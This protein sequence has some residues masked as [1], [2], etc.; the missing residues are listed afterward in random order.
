MFAHAFVP[1]HQTYQRCSISR[2]LCRFLQALTLVLMS[3]CAT[4]D[5]DP[6][7]RL[8][9]LNDSEWAKAHRLPDNGPDAQWSHQ[10]L[11]ARIATR[12]QPVTHAGRPALHALSERGDSLVRLPVRAEGPRLGQLRF[13]WF[14]SELNPAAELGDSARD[15]AVVRVILQFDGDRAPF[16][17][18]DRRLSEMVHLATGEPLPHATLMYVWDHHHPVGTVLRHPRTDRVRVLVVAS[19]EAGLGR[20]VDIER[21]IAADY[22]LAFG[23]SPVRLIGLAIMTDANNTGQRAEAWYGPITWSAHSMH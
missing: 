23:K 20:W 1:I 6:G 14:V 3:G 13:S 5:N 9:L 21:D 10:H 8:K 18:R 22:T 15:D 2:G 16:S 12:Y 11:P 19:G 4:W 17:A 7:A